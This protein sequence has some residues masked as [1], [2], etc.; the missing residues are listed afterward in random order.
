[1]EVCLIS[2]IFYIVMLFGRRFIKNFVLGLRIRM[3]RNE[4]LNAVAG[5]FE[6][7]L[8][9]YVCVNPFLSGICMT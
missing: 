1:V 8:M 3:L 7:V 9:S 2:F 5:V 4:E 6:S